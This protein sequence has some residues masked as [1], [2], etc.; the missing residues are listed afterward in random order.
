M[1]NV[2]YLKII[3]DGKDYAIIE[4]RVEFYGNANY[5]LKC[6]DVLKNELK[7]V[8]EEKEEAASADSTV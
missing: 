5:N 4:K 3:N 2:K 6:F 8:Q 1:S 7:K